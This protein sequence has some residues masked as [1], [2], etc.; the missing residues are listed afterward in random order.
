MSL[1][2]TWYSPEAAAEQFGINPAQILAWVAEG[3]VRAE[4]EGEK[5]SLVN[6]D[7]VRLEVQAMVDRS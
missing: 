5:V 2:K 1:V 7:D 4:Q 6:I 3:L